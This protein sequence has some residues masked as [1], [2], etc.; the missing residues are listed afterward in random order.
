MMKIC[1]I[2]GRYPLTQFNSSV[3]H[4][5]YADTYGYTYINCNYPTQAK[6]P[7]LNKIYYILSYVDNY[8]Y[9]IWIDD[10][11]FFFDFSKDVMDYAPQN[12]KFI[13]FCKSPSFKEL[14]TFLSSGQFVLKTNELSK[15]FLEEILTLNMQKIQDWWY[16]DLGYFSKGD[17]DLIIYL[18][19][20]KNAYKG[21]YELYNYKEFNSRV[22]NLFGEDSHKPFILHFTGT[23]D[24]KKNNYKKVQ[25]TLSLHSSLVEMEL[26]NKYNIVKEDNYNRLTKHFFK[27]LRKWFYN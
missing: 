26:L 25:E 16:D 19:L 6:N 15:A 2:S 10:D 20:V 12:D 7:Y 5:L 24:I 13:S 22:E 14:K 11:A 8:D 9:I 1:I 21:K 3:N 18:L 4:K 17:Q 23:P 27:K